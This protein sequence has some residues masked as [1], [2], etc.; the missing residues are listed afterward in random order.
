MPKSARP[1]KHVTNEEFDAAWMNESNR[2]VVFA[3]VGRART[4][5]TPDEMESVAARALWKALSYHLEEYGQLFTS[6]LHRVA[7]WT[8]AGELRTKVR[9]EA[10][11]QRVRSV[12][13]LRR[14]PDEPP[15]ASE[16]ATYVAELLA[17]L[18]DA[19]QA[20][21]LRE[22]YLE[23]RTAE[24]IGRSR[25]YSRETS[26]QRLKA[27]LAAARDLPAVKLAG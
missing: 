4:L 15:G 17:M 7:T 3:V 23:G 19:E 14:E 24:E 10:K 2:K 22:Y 18:E 13:R 11:A 6:T 21:L 9:Q 26:R 20:S 16:D 27:A 8:L 5:L 25:G 1:R 12:E